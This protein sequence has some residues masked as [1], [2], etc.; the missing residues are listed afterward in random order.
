MTGWLCSARWTVP[1]DTPNAFAMSTR[2]VFVLFI[3]A[4]GRRF[5][6]TFPQTNPRLYTLANQWVGGDLPRM[7]P[8]PLSKCNRL[9]FERFREIDDRKL[10]VLHCKTS[11]CRVRLG[12]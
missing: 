10:K 9:Q 5:E 3:G 1:I 12:E 4:H 6:K 11:S 8:Q 7:L 2:V